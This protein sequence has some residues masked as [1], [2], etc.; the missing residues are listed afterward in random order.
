MPVNRTGGQLPRHLRHRGE[1]YPIAGQGWQAACSQNAPGERL[2]HVARC[3]YVNTIM[4]PSRHEALR[5]AE[6]HVIERARV[7]QRQQG[8][9]RE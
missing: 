6:E 5:A 7:A 9:G 8:K 3:D 4:Y 1:A 2:D